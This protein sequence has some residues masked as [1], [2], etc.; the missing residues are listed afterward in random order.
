MRAITLFLLLLAA[1]SLGG[2]PAGAECIS[3]QNAKEKMGVGEFR[4][5]ALNGEKMTE[6]RELF[7]KTYGKSLRE[8]DSALV[9]L[10]H[11]MNTH[12]W[13]ILFQDGCAVAEGPLGLDAYLSMTG[14]EVVPAPLPGEETGEK[15]EK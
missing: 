10:K 14:E 7:E 15:G 6:L 5:D 13:M 12:A 2:G 8:S 4:V 1:V 11:T 9:F 3:P